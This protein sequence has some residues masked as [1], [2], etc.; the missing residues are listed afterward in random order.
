MLMTPG[1]EY[2]PGKEEAVGEV[3]KRLGLVLGLNVP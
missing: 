3:V 2:R 1:N